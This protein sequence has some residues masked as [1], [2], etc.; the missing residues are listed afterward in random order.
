VH[1]RLVRAAARDH[2]CASDR[3]SH[4]GAVVDHG[5][6]DEASS[7]RLDGSTGNARAVAFT[8]DH[9]RVITAGADGVA[10]IWDASK[11]SLIGKRVQRDA[12]TSLALTADGRFL[13]VGRRTRRCRRG[14][15]AS[16]PDPPT[17]S[18]SSSSVFHGNSMM[19]TSCG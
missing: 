16:R 11:G 13:W 8:P 6:V 18:R 9:S 4:D 7:V 17:S 3:V 15:S 2:R 19:T 14:T 5:V 12:I 1:D 10:Q